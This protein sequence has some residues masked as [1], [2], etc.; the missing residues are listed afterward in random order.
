MPFEWQKSKACDVLVDVSSVGLVVGVCTNLEQ[1]EDVIP[2]VVVAQR[3]VQHLEIGVV[4]ILKDEGGRLG[5]WVPYDVEELDD[6]GAAVQVLQDLDLPLD[7][8]G[9]CMGI[10]CREQFCV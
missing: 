8:S 2:Y 5:L 6:V 3:C 4:D 9:C 1:L 7:L 10:M